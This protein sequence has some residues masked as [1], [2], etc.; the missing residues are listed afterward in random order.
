MFKEKY[1]K[2]ACHDPKHGFTTKARAWKD[3]DRK[4]NLGVT[5]TFLGM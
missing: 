2:V 1:G 4:Y 5:F 3:A